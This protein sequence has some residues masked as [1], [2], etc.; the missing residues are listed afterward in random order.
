MLS[1]SSK[2]S[3]LGSFRKHFHSLMGKCSKLWSKQ[4]QS[5]QIAEY[6]YVQ[7]GVY[8]KVPNKT[9]WN[10][11][12][13]ELKQLHEL[14]STVPLKMNA[15]MDQCSLYRITTAETVVVQEYTEIMGPL[16]QSLDTLQQ[17]NG[18][19]MG[20]LLPMLYNLDHKLD[21]L[22]NKPVRYTYCFQLL[23]GVHE[24]LRKQFAAFWEDKR[25]LL[26]ACLHPRFKLEWLESRQATTHTNKHTME[27]LLKAEIKMGALNE[28]RDQ[29]SDKDQ[30]GND[31]ENDFFN[32]ERQWTLLM[33]NC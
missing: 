19:F 6:I 15:I 12:F 8:L 2:S 5:A 11:T 16:A 24:A 18:M 31:L 25:L 33:R 3:L 30:E 7:C 10:S 26:A 23:R 32:I 14:L 29:S 21:E 28:D 20:Y 22:E 27:A 13:Y 4:N 17:E 1:D 9:R